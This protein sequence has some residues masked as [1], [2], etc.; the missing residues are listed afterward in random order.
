[1]IR[2]WEYLNEQDRAALRTTVAFLSKRL[3]EAATIEWALSLKPSQRIERLALEDLLDGTD[4]R[5][6][7]EPWATAWRLIERKL[8]GW[9]E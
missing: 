4:G 9:R 1:M 8:V 7:G 5:L 6:L 2:G 3:A